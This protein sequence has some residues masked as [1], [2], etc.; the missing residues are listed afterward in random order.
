M[1]SR[2]PSDIPLRIPDQARKS[3]NAESPVVIL[4]ALS[5]PIGDFTTKEYTP[6]DVCSTD[7]EIPD[8]A[9]KEFNWTPKIKLDQLVSEMID[10]DRAIAQREL[11]NK[12]RKI[13][14]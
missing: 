7:A 5:A 11:D 9:F 14:K 10:H 3:F 1:I 2:L 8:K 4:I 6:A 13:A 12:Q